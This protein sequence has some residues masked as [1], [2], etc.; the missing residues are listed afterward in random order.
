MNVPRSSKRDPD[1]GYDV[2]E[3]SSRDPVAPHAAESWSDA[4]ITPLQHDFYFYDL[5]EKVFCLERLSSEK[6]STI[7]DLLLKLKRL[8]W[9]NNKNDLPKEFLDDCLLDDM[10]VRIR[11]LEH[12]CVTKDSSIAGLKASA[13]NQKLISDEYKGELEALKAIVIADT[14]PTFEC[15]KKKEVFNLTHEIREQTLELHTLRTEINILKGTIIPDLKN[16]LA[17]KDQTILRLENE[18]G[19]VT[20]SLLEV[21]EPIS[22]NC[23]GVDEELQNQQIHATINHLKEK[24]LQVNEQQDLQQTIADLQLQLAR[25]QAEVDETGVELEST[26]H[27]LCVVEE[28]NQQLQRTI[29]HAPK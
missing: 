29:D 22:P 12:D 14:L 4:D 23:D 2:T 27:Q 5:A 6:D 10:E 26:M 15:K 9:Q 3:S 24:L 13:E 21:Q 7:A 1:E 17:E 11:Q 16:Q 28:R 8:E 25:K 18:K 20:M 19:R